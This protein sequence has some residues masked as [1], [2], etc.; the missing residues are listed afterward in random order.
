ME[1]W[2]RKI[3]FKFVDWNT[4]L[5]LSY[6]H[7]YFE[8]KHWKSFWFNSLII[9][10]EIFSFCFTVKDQFEIN[11]ILLK[12]SGSNLIRYNDDIESIF[13]LLKFN[14]SNLMRYN[15]IELISTWSTMLRLKRRSTQKKKRKKKDRQ[16]SIC[17][18]SGLIKYNAFSQK[19]ILVRSI[20]NKLF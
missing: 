14:D 20:N 6:V 4:P 9:F 12:F 15:D 10:L 3:L 18:H 17:I 1:I 11:N 2:K 7:K 19:H 8:Q 5:R 16:K 13:N